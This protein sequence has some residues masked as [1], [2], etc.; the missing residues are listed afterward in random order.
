MKNALFVAYK[1]PFVSSNHFLSRLK[2]KYKVKKAGFSGTLDPFAKGVLLIAFG[3]YPKLFSYLQKAP[4]TYRATLWLGAHSP[5]LDIEQVTQ[6]DSVPK[7]SYT[8]LEK[9][10]EDFIG[11]ISYLPP[12]YSAKKIDG[13]RAYALSRANKVFELKQIQSTV[14]SIELLQYSH[15]FITFEI[16]VSEGAYIRSIA[17]LIAQKLGYMGILSSLERTKEGH[18]VYNCEKKLNPL[19]YLNIQENRY[20]GDIED[21]LLGK[22]LDIGHF[23]HTDDGDYFLNLKEFLSIISIYQNC[24]TYKLNRIELC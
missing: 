13:Q 21:V 7:L 12:K 6:I 11:E 2:R 24:V 16:T 1:P 19:E 4:K 14:Y 3:Q 9:T 10:L 18:F 20:M 8:H 15:P 23:E 5:T 22:K 17:S